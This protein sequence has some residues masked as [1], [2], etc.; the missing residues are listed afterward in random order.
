MTGAIAHYQAVL[1]AILAMFIAAVPL[2][3]S[4]YRTTPPCLRAE[5][6]PDLC[7][8]HPLGPAVE[9]GP[10]R[11]PQVAWKCEVVIIWEP[12]MCISKYLACQVAMRVAPCGV[13]PIECADLEFA[14]EFTEP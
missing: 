6:V 8:A 14:C 2:G 3:P 13:C 10:E 4:R 5:Q 12:T 9:C 11:E 7:E 1:S